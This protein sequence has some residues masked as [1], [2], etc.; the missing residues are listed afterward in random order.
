MRKAAILSCVV[1]SVVCIAVVLRGSAGPGA[2]AAPRPGHS[3]GFGLRLAGAWHAVMDMGAGT[4]EWVVGIT[5]DGVV[6]GNDTSRQGGM[7]Q[8]RTGIGSWKRIGQNSAASTSLVLIEN[9]DGNLIF[10]ERVVL[11]ITLD[12]DEFSGSAKGY[13]Y[14]PDQDPWD[15]AETPINVLT[16]TVFA[17]RIVVQTLSE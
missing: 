14:L 9:P 6:I 8:L 17:R 1:L 3:I 11:E 12:G 13:V 15:P 4:T 7:N 5:A 2:A 10:Y 16:G